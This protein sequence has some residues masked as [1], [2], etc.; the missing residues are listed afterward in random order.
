MSAPFIAIS[1]RRW[2]G[3]RVAGFPANFASVEVDLAISDYAKCVAA[4]GAIPLAVPFEADP[5]LVMSR[6]DGLVLTGGS[7]VDPRLY[8][9]PSNACAGEIEPARDAYEAALF[10]A[11]VAAGKPVL[12]I[13]R[14]AQL[15]N[16]ALGGTLVA[17]LD[18]STGHP[19]W[20]FPRHERVHPVALTPGSIVATSH[21]AT[22]VAVNSLHHQSVDRPG[23]GVIV[24]GVSPDG[25][26]EAYEVPGSR[27]LAVQWHPELLQE[28]PDPCFNWLVNEASRR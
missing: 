13:C 27:V 18:A 11:A 9:A 8:G 4:A 10:Q 24:T 12:A 16:V 7:D 17:D 15:V 25:V 21:D 1:G 6:L 26:I 14:G 19:A 5:H 3:H 23:T 2:L 28:Q 20:G 22:T